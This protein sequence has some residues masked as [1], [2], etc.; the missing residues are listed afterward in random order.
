MDDISNNTRKL[1]VTEI[2]ISPD[3]LRK[4]DE[5]KAQSLAVSIEQDGQ[6]QPIAVYHSSRATLPYTL[7][8]GLHRWE[9]HNILGLETI[10]VIVRT[11]KEALRLEVAENLF[12]FD[13]NLLDRATFAQKWAE[14]TGVKMGRPKKGEKLDRNVLLFGG[15]TVSDSEAERMGL[16]GKAGQRFRQ[17]ENNLNPELKDIFRGTDIANNQAKLLKCAK[18]DPQKQR[19]LA[20]AFTLEGG[21]LDK[22]FKIIEPHKGRM[23]E[24]ARLF[25]QAI[26]AVGRMKKETK[27]Q[28]WQHFGMMEKPLNAVPPLLKPSQEAVRKPGNKS[29]LWEMIEAPLEGREFVTVNMNVM[30]YSLKQSLQ[31]LKNNGL[32]N[33]PKSDLR[34]ALTAEEIS[35]VAQEAKKPPK[36][37]SKPKRRRKAS[38]K[39]TAFKNFHPYL[40]EQLKLKKLDTD[41][42][43]LNLLR[44]FDNEGQ[45]EMGLHFNAGDT[46]DE[47]YKRA[48]WRLEAEAEKAEKEKAV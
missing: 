22:A 31:F 3:R 25:G 24:E 7:I 28:F 32:S 8:F 6:L 35:Q 15:R 48:R 33:L 12:R 26:D 43:L 36:A 19:E 9:A 46:R 30:G 11:A 14:L 20:V 47:M 10:D 29:L 37:S 34:N 18:L 4:L 23:N 42:Q 5:T 39:Q 41:T 13:L 17:I 44:K 38:V 21:N 1:R 45:H 2:L 27:A 16:T 40:V